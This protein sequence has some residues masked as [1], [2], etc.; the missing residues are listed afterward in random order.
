[1][2]GRRNTQ[3]GRHHGRRGLAAEPG[4]RES[5]LGDRLSPEP[6]EMAHQVIAAGWLRFSLP[7]HGTIATQID[8]IAQSLGTP[9]AGRRHWRRRRSH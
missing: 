3:F 2:L 8:F 1:M 9:V 6:S 7:E 5:H 4:P